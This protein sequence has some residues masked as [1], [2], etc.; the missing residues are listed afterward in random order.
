MENILKLFK[1]IREICDYKYINKLDGIK[2]RDKTDGIQLIDAFFYKFSYAKLHTKKEDICSLI[3]SKKLTNHHRTSFDRKEKNIPTRAYEDILESCVQFYNANCRTKSKH[4]L[5]AV[6]GTNN[7]NFDRNVMLNMGYF[8]ITNN[9]PIDL[10]YDGSKNRNKEVMRF[11]EYVRNNLDKFKNAIFVCDRAYFSYKLIH[12]LQINKLKYV[13]RVK[14]T[15]DNIN[16]NTEINKYIKD[17]KIVKYLR[18]FTRVIECKSEFTKNVALNPN[19][20]KS[21]NVHVSVKFQ[22]ICNLVTNLPNIKKYSQEKIMDIYKSRW[23][24]ET[25]FK[26]VKNNFKFQYLNEKNEEQGRRLYLCE[27][28]LIYIA[29]II[30]YYHSRSSFFSKKYNLQKYSIKPN[31]SLMLRGIYDFLLSDV[32]TGKVTLKILLEYCKLYIHTVQNELNR[33]FPRTSKTFGTKWYIKQYSDCSKM[34]VILRAIDT[35]TA[36]A[37]N[38]NLKLIIKNILEINGKKII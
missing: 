14:G 3:N 15:G 32:L 28:S 26:L 7:S 29:K 23:N 33:R 1:N 36:H 6:D 2:M 8:D 9:I 34:A 13:I 24:I 10:T 27:L 16:P 11:M 25:F 20:R 37:L 35:N 18:K 19:K 4:V 38:K 22:N 17:Y 12:F 5:I 31:D 30:S 21:G